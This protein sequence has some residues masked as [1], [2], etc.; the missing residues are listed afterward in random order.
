MARRS[1]S[2]LARVASLKEPGNRLLV[3]FCFFSIYIIWGS[4]Y[5]AIRF[6]V[7]S[8]P[9]LFTAAMRHLIAGTILLVWALWKGAKPT[10]AQIRASAVIG[11]FF[12]LVGH[13][14][15]HWA[16]QILPSGLAS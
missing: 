15:L 6:A 13:G 14:S 7:E 8:I 2:Q 9:A 12:F 5:L 10:W 3:I 1:T 16:E 11:F 4:T